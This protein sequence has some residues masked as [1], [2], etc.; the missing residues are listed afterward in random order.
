VSTK[1]IKRHV[2]AER[3]AVYRALLDAEAVA[4]W[5]V[6][7]GMRSVVHEFDPR[8]GG[9]FRISLIY[10]S[11]TGA[12]KTNARTDTYHGHFGRLVANEQV[13]EVLEFETDDPDLRGEMTMT[14]TLA[15]A[16]V[17]TDVLVTYEGLPIGV[18]VEDNEVGTRMA[19]DK[20]AKLVESG[21]R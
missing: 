10:E 7:D 13:V 5:R 20:L 6:P 17:G 4:G 9:S 14:T 2:R 3:P 18:S 11:P 16:D 21:G 12:G 15:D 1:A 8:E 19:L